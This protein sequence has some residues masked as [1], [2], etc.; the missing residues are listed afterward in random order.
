MQSPRRFLPS[1]ALLSAFEKKDTERAPTMVTGL[2]NTKSLQ[3]E[4]AALKAEQK[5]TAAKNAYDAL[6]QAQKDQV[7][8]FLD[9]L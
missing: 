4:L 8:A 2:D 9:S 3:E 5:A 6:S 1:L 7:L